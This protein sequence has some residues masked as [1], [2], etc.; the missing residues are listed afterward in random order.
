M[1]WKCRRGR[2]PSLHSC[3]WVRPAV[4]G[5]TGSVGHLSQN[6]VKFQ[7]LSSL[8]E[9]QIWQFLAVA[10]SGVGV[11]W[12][13]VSGLSI[14][15]LSVVPLRAQSRDFPEKGSWLGNVKTLRPLCFRNKPMKD[16]EGGNLW[17]KLQVLKCLP[18]QNEPLLHIGR[19]Q[20]LQ[21]VGS[22]IC[23]LR[24]C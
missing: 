8:W 22:R 14:E 18:S 7:D 2:I 21:V 12:I 17:R 1:C 10:N 24:N 11:S 23:V 3:G 4:V 13:H 16:L 9:L 19:S 6:S 15:G 5:K 20:S